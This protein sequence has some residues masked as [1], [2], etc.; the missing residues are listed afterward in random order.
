MCVVTEV[1][2]VLDG[3]DGGGVVVSLLNLFLFSFLFLFFSVLIS[4]WLSEY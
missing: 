3:G 2:F 1:V 4:V